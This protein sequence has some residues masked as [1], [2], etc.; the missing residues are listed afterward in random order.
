MPTPGPPPG[1]DI[2]YLLAVPDPASGQ[3]AI[4]MTITN[5]D[6]DEVILISPCPSTTLR[7]ED[8]DGDRLVTET[9]SSRRVNV[10]CAEVPE[11]TV[12]YTIQPCRATQSEYEGYIGSDFAALKGDDV[13]VDTEPW[14]DSVAVAFDLPPGWSAHTPWRRDGPAYNPEVTDSWSPVTS[15]GRTGM[16]LGRFDAYTR[17]VGKTEVIIAAYAGWPEAVRR[18]LAEQAWDILDYQTDVFGCSIGDRYLAIFCPVAADGR[19]I[20]AS[21]NALSQGWSIAFNEDGSYWGRWDMFAHGSFHRWNG[22]PPWHMWVWPQW[23]K[24]GGDVLYEMKTITEL[25]IERPYGGM[26]EELAR[27]YDTYLTEYLGTDRDRPVV[28]VGSDSWIRYRKSAMV[29]FLLAREIYSRTEGAQTFDDWLAV[30][31]EEY[32][33]V[34]VWCKTDCLQEELELLTGTDFGEFFNDYVYGVAPLPMEWASEDDDLDGLSNALEIGWDTDFQDDDTD[35]D[36]YGDGV[37]VKNLSDPLDR[38]SIPRLIYLPVVM[39]K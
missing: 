13:I 28:D 30:L 32:S 39:R 23:F 7:V 12:K 11:F 6:L 33:G 25:R 31:M 34:Y 14:A 16:A 9:L 27:Y 8:I 37:E 21:G 17:T 18:S 5:R 29:N 10:Q 26:E 24:E 22:Y 36:G 4:K 19:H 35:G 38:A 1:V 15:L 20:V 2:H 3:A